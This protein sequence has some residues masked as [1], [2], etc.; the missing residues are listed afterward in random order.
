MMLK[1]LAES[2]LKGNDADTKSLNVPHSVPKE[3]MQELRNIA[4]HLLN[5]AGLT[6]MNEML[7]S[8]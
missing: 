2:R 7:K 4:A 3:I 5:K 8:F 6:E 1:N